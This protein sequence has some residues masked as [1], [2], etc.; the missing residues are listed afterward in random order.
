MAFKDIRF[1]ATDTVITIYYGDDRRQITKHDKPTDFEEI[2]AILRS[3]DKDPKAEQ[4]LI[5]R[6]KA[7]GASKIV[8]YSKGQFKIDPGANRVYDNATKT[9]VGLVLARRII[10][11]EREGLPFEPL[12]Q[13]HRRVI[14]NPSKESANDLYAFLEANHVPITEDG[15]F[16]AY[17]KV[18]T[19]NGKLV[20]SHTGTISNEV[21]SR[22]V[23]PREKVDPNRNNT[24]S[25][26]LHVGAHQYVSHFSGDTI[27]E[28]K[29]NPTDVV[30]VPPDYKQQKMRV[31]AYVVLR[32]RGD[33]ET[34]RTAQMVT[35]PDAGGGAYEV[36]EPPK[37]EEM[38]AREIKEWVKANLRE[39]ITLDPKNKRAIVKKAYSIFASVKDAADGEEGSEEG[40]YN[41]D[42]DN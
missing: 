13:F 8:A 40:A 37:F 25:S 22:V 17:K 27:I 9:D 3:A 31:C 12:L 1:T 24:C 39:E 42:D 32:R 35:T 5:A 15:M 34:E 6:L 36:A 41:D 33:K 23:M 10:A 7:G 38:T 18:T 28:V 16:I 21:G 20:D 2:K 29:V 14:A 30:A 11:W 26:G 19:K 4:K